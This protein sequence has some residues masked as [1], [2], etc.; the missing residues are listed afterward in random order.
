M[1]SFSDRRGGIWELKGTFLTYSRVRDRLGI[2]LTDIASDEGS[3][4]KKFASDQWAI[5]EV[6]WVMVADQ[7]ASLSI[8]KDQF[9]D[10][11]TEQTLSAATRALIAEMLFFSQKGSPTH[12]ILTVVSES[13]DGTQEAIGKQAEALEVEMRKVVKQELEAMSALG[14]SAGNGQAQPDSTATTTA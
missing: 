12:S 1:H 6:L 13:F 7:A 8:T 10:G 2:D 9:L 5:V 14:T 4:F 3:C 11:F